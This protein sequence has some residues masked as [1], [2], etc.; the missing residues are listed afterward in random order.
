MLAQVP[1]E[2]DLLD[3]V[4]ALFA[5][6][7]YSTVTEAKL[8]RKRIDVLFV[9]TVNGRWIAVELKLRDWK[10][11]LWQAAVN[12]QLADNSYIG[13]W[14][15]SIQCALEQRKLFESY[16]VGIIS[17]TPEEAHI[18]LDAQDLPNSTRVRKQQNVLRE[19]RGVPEV[20][21]HIDAIALL[22]A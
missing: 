12:L 15:P 18:V 1:K 3:P 20:E 22:P 7:D 8:S 21:G 19:M 13:L 5:G 10:T 2:S 11:A 4:V 14:Q 17:V 16:G 9:P 6:R